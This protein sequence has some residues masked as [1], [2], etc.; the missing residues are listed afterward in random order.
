VSTET[1]RVAARMFESLPDETKQTIMVNESAKPWRN[2]DQ[3]MARLLLVLT[4]TL[5]LIAPVVIVE[6]WRAAL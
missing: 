5:L 4:Y 1:E 3:A 6:A 2:T